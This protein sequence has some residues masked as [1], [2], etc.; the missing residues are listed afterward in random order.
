MSAGG[1]VALRRTPQTPHRRYEAA[2]P[3]QGL[4]ERRHALPLER[5]AVMSRAINVQATSDEVRKACHKQGCEIS[6]IEA[7]QSGG[8]RVVLMNIEATT[9]MRAA[10][11]RKVIVGAVS[12]APL[13]SW[14]R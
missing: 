5:G 3:E 12:R 11:G 1:A 7:L 10:F 13:R 9:A 8:T 4:A 6:A 2:Q 14:R